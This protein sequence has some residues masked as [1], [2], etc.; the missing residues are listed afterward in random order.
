[1]KGLTKMKF[2]FVVLG[3]TGEQG[4]IAAR[5]LANNGYSVLACGRNLGRVKPLL[6][7]PKV[8]FAYVNVRDANQTASLIKKSGAKIV[9]NCVELRL[10]IDVM[11]SCLKAGVHYLDLG[12]LQEMTIQQYKLDQDFRKKKLIG[13][14]GCGSTPGIAN[15]MA[16]H[17][18][19]QLDSVYHI[20]VGFAWDSNVKKFVLPYSIESIVYELTTPP[21]VLE[22]GKFEK[23]KVCAL[24]KIGP[25]REVGKQVIYCIVHSE[26][27]TFGKYF[28]K[29][30]IERVHYAAG[31]PEH[32]HK[33]L[34]LLIDFGFG[35]GDYIK[36]DGNEIKIIDYTREI[37]KIAKHPKN[38]KEV[39]NIWVKAIGEKDGQAKSISMNCVTKTLKGFE[40]AGSNINTGMTISIMGQILHQGKINAIGV[41]APEVCIP[42]EDFFGELAKRKIVIYQDNKRI[43]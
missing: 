33:V 41:T 7:N 19:N 36:V 3:A 34:K 8:K 29:K 11:K 14:L 25:L 4:S 22:G 16:R 9:L 2:D 39:E 21:V 18:V 10:N 35:S 30:G 38:Y 31:F 37:L 12:G 1:M 32:S 40:D 28:K 15:V 5:D 27:Y 42:S 17:A 24:E 20:D 43:N 26:V 6:K 13:L 23:K